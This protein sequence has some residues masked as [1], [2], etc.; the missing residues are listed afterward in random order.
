MEGT[1]LG[2]LLLAGALAGDGPLPVDPGDAVA[3]LEVLERAR[4]AGA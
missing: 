4:M 1:A 2:S 3:A